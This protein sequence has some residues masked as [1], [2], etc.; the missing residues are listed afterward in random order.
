MEAIAAT[1]I[2][3]VKGY[4]LRP[5]VLKEEVTG[6]TITLR[7]LPTRVYHHVLAVAG[8]DDEHSH[9]VQTQEKVAFSI[10]SIDGLGEPVTFTN[11]E[12]DG[13]QYPRL[14][15][16]ILDMLPIGFLTILNLEIHKYNLLTPE[17]LKKLNFTIA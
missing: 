10:K 7:H 3:E 14:D 12:I 9:L 5:R 13:R 11:V 1:E 6:L 4:K 2:S 16:N 15:D 17:E 8:D